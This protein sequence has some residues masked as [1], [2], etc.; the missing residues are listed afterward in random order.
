MSEIARDDEPYLEIR[1]LGL[2][3]KHPSG[4]IPVLHDIS[5]PIL[6]AEV[7][8]IVGESGSGK[9]MSMRSISGL[10]PGGSEFSLSGDL[11][12]RGRPL[13]PGVA[14]NQ[15]LPKFAMIFQDPKR[16]L[17]PGLRAGQHVT[18]VLRYAQ[19]FGARD[20][21]S[22]RTQRAREILKRVDLPTSQRFFRSFP[23]ELSGGM[24]Q[25]LVIA[26]VVAGENDV[27]IADEAITALDSGTAAQVLD[28]FRDIAGNMGKAVVYI[29]HDLKTVERIASNVAVF[30]AGYTVEYRK[31]TEF[32]STPRH[33]YSRMLME[34]HPALRDR[35]RALKI[36]PG[37]AASPADPPAGCP[38]HPRCPRVQP[39]CRE[40]LPELIPDSSGA[41]RCH[42]PYPESN[43]RGKG[44]AAGPNDDAAPEEVSHE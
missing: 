19:G 31:S 32:F 22:R 5:L 15:S 42:F 1:G 40:V 8:A 33:P 11:L 39:I 20:S 30:Y 13:V 2:S 36:I 43:R 10:L 21:H 35:G 12:Y 29:S 9:T 41:V 18:E 44:S 25:R 28:L 7:T 4:E 38:F 37:E 14:P 24:Q 16:V 34:S 26:C 23:H 3:A 6:S 27:L 17:N